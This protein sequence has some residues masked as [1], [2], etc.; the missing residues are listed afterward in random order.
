MKK[1]LASLCMFVLFAAS[2]ATAQ[3]T[4]FNHDFANATPGEL[5]ASGGLGT[6]MAGTVT[7]TGGFI[8]SGNQT[9]TSGNNDTSNS[10]LVDFV[11]VDTF[12]AD[13]NPV[14][15]ADGNPV[16]VPSFLDQ[17]VNDVGT[18][19]GNF[20]TVDFSE[21]AAVT[22]V[23][24]AGQTTTVDFQLASFGTNNVRDFKY[25][26][27]LGRSSTG[28]EVFQILWRAGSGAATRQVFARE[29][30][31]DNTTFAD[32][33]VSADGGV[34]GTLILS[35]VGFNINNTNT[36]N[37]PSGRVS[38]SITIDENG[39]NASAVQPA[40]SGGMQTPATGLGIASGATD[41]AS[42]VFFSSHN[43]NVDTQNKG[44]WIDNVVVTTDLTVE[45][46]DPV[47]GDLNGDG[48]T[49]CADIDEFIGN[50]GLS[51][52]GALADLDLV[53]DGTIDSLDV[54]FL[55]ENLVV[56]SPN[57]V[58]GTALGDLNCDG[59]VNVLGDAF[60]LVASL[61]NA[62]TSYSQ[63]DINL[64]GTVNVLGDAFTLVAN[65]GFSNAN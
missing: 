30:G 7:A 56:T 62:A 39:W 17:T 45:P 11:L 35:N 31:E 49:D 13:G 37:A 38:V 59:Q 55:V 54:A 29:L 53:A 44:L 2:A 60:I 22:G 65:L 24:G 63:G 41:L 10:I 34:D 40:G 16:Q 8:S 33:A 12:D 32:D 58:T 50:L 14:L 19:A 6:P 64:D 18:P 61:N 48:V 26:H 15:D 52:V 20:L 5:G 27:I 9:Y 3:T 57:G 25:V 21:P 51:A 1:I 42:I 36:N 46:G 23:L 28:A 43:A 4:V 47:V